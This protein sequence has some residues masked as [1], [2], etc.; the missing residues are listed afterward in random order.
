MAL[1]PC[2]PD[3]EANHVE[4]VLRESFDPGRIQNVS[5]DFIVELGLDSFGHS[6]EQMYLSQ[7]EL[8]MH[9][10]VASCEMG[11]HGTDVHGAFRLEKFQ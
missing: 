9:G 4:V 3:P 10:L 1:I 6:F 5:P 8:V 2:K 7:C 11:E